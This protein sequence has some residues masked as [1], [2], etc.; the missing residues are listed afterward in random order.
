MK[1]IT[2]TIAF[3]TAIISSVPAY[4][5]ELKS[6]TFAPNQPLPKSMEFN[7]FGC[8]GGNKSP[9]LSW[10]NAPEGTKSFAVT[11]HDPDAPTTSGWWHWTVYNIPANT[12]ELAEGAKVP[13][14][15]LEGFTDYGTTGF[16]G[17]CPPQGDKA[18][19]YN[20]TI[21]ALK[22]EKLD[23]DPKTTSGAK[24]TYMLNANALEKAVLTGTYQRQ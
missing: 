24:L 3:F 22:T 14:G 4:S 8:D 21:Y 17:A 5:L 15:A 12:S 23:L 2:R 13:D 20:I 1:K 10:S 16:G 11:I 7:G 9:Q 6:S 18:H 19:R